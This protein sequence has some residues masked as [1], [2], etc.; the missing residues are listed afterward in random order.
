MCT[1]KHGVKVGLVDRG[2]APLGGFVDEGLWEV[3]EGL[4][5]CFGWFCGGQVARGMVVFQDPILQLRCVQTCAAPLHLLPAPGATSCPAWRCR[6]RCLPSLLALPARG[7]AC[8][9]KVQPLASNTH[10]H[11]C[12][13]SDKVASQCVELNY[14]CSNY[15]KASPW[16]VAWDALMDCGA[17]ACIHTCMHAFL[18]CLASKV[19]CAPGNSSRKTP[20]WYAQIAT[21]W[22]WL[23]PYEDEE[24]AAAAAAKSMQ[25]KV[26]SLLS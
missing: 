22:L 15:C 6:C 19:K 26:A 10:T 16:F 8:V 25:V 13:D 2:M 1:E 23:G 3:D 7:L 17:H 12:S 14:S 18:P 11:T 21:A 9:S 4:W 20:G 5:E 24:Q